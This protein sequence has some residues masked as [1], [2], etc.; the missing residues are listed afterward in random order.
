MLKKTLLTD[1]LGGTS[2]FSKPSPAPTR[3]TSVRPQKRL[4]TAPSPTKSSPTK[5]DEDKSVVKRTYRTA[6]QYPGVTGSTKNQ[7][8]KDVAARIRELCGEVMGICLK[9]AEQATELVVTRQ[10][11]GTGTKGAARLAEAVQD[12][13]NIGQS[14][15]L[16]LIETTKGYRR[17]IK[18]LNDV[19]K[20]FKEYP[21]E[22][23]SFVYWGRSTFAESVMAIKWRVKRTYARNFIVGVRN[24]LDN[25]FPE[26]LKLG[27][28]WKS[29]SKETFTQAGQQL[30]KEVQERIKERQD[31]KKPV[32]KT[33]TFANKVVKLTESA[34]KI[35]KILNQEPLTLG[36]K[37]LRNRSKEVAQ[38]LP[39]RAKK[40][41]SALRTLLSLAVS[42]PLQAEPV[43]SQ[44]IGV[45]M[46]VPTNCL[47]KPFSRYHG[48]SSASSDA[49]PSPKLQP[50][51]LVMGSKYVI[52][53]PGN[54]TQLT[55][56]LKD[57]LKQ[58]PKKA[59]IPLIIPSTVPVLGSI[60]RLPAQVHLPMSHKM[61]QILLQGA[62]LTL[63]RLMP[64]VGPSQK[65]RVDLVFEGPVSAFIATKHLKK[66]T[67]AKAPP[68]Q[69]SPKT[70]HVGVDVNRP[71]PYILAYYPQA[72]LS[73]ILLDL[74]QSYLDKKKVIRSIH[75]SISLAE[76]DNTLPRARKLR[77][78][79]NLVYT[80]RA[81]L[82]K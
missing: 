6:L 82:L 41:H 23:A 47:G 51:N 53:R 16:T 19:Q 10:I 9:H 75:R 67:S 77:Q 76:K 30:Q 59:G 72:R 81:N 42:P 69:R 45:D 12:R 28:T 73:Q 1:S 33:Q 13:S 46:I 68:F 70:S 78:E 36:W 65:V 56:L 50:I 3:Y 74:C 34:E 2:P 18:K 22:W 37:S 32:D 44:S 15:Y 61:R 21:Q 25:V 26:E 62:K 54:Y 57:Q 80:R 64:P 71:G 63:I 39:G 55:T 11:S 40:Y 8:K 7:L 5:T 20:F 38:A 60:R 27:A 14:A 48:S 31:Q 24:K 58:D 79:L 29:I 35:L 43:T 4:V 52:K 49:S 66:P 17:V